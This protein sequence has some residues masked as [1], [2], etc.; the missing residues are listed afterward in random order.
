MCFIFILACLLALNVSAFAP[1]QVHTRSTGA[2]PTCRY[3]S[4]N[5]DDECDV[6]VIG[7]GIGGLSCAALC[8]KYGLETICLEAHDTAGGVAHSFTRYSK[9]SKTTPFC[10]D[11]GPS[12][13]TGLSKKGTNPLRQVLDAV[14]VADDIEWRTYDGWVIHDLSD[15]KS[16]R[17]TT[18]D[19]GQFEQALEEKAGR[20]SREAFEAFKNNMLGPKG[21]SEAS[22][23]IPPFA[24]R[25]GARAMFS[26]AKYTLKLLSI[27]SKGN[28]LTG[29]FTDTMDYYNMHD[30]FI[31]KWFDYL[32][33]ALS[34]EDAAHTQGAP[35]AYMMSDLHRPGAV[36]DYPIGGMDSLIQALVSGLENHGGE[37]SLKSRVERILIEDQS[38]SCHCSGVVLDNGR[39]IRAKHGVV[40]NAPLWNTVQILESSVDASDSDNAEIIN[41]VQEMRKQADDMAMTGSFMHLHLG[42]PSEGLADD[43]E[44][45]HSVLNMDI[46]IT[47]EQNMV[48]ISIPTVF[49]KNLAPEGYHVVHAYTAA[50][51]SFDDWER[52]IEKDQ[53]PTYDPNSSASSKNTIVKLDIRI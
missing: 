36:L 42:I 28:F 17:L 10:F 46:D 27:G 20:Q 22:A 25:G 21:L 33:F 18:G 16:F 3:F 14:G 1:V 40:T 26:L 11:A 45:H 52:F 35:V 38:G 15:G 24:L 31:R 48:I 39:V 19:G 50:C 7:A 29:P 5:D 51:D 47:A 37:L 34:G 13:I 30:P 23:Y 9:A 49:D 2:L 44:C 6:V 41:A 43:L 4:A 8:A 12:L 53:K 32:A